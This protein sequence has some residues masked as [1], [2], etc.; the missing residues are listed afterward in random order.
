MSDNFEKFVR[1]NRRDFDSETPAA[2]VWEKIETSLPK[3]QVRRFTIRDIYKWSAAAAIVVVVLTSAYF[4]IFQRNSHEPKTNK[5]VVTVTPNEADRIV[6]EYADEFNAVYRAIGERSLELKTNTAAYP[7]LYRQFQED[8]ASLD[9][10]Y[11][12]LMK[13]ADHSPNQDLLYQAIIQNLR[14]RADLLSRQL[15]ITHELKNKTKKSNS[16]EKEI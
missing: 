7:E 11:Q 4:L 5:P 15:M 1:N 3:Q 9:S 12:A 14:L 8:M 13:Q 2:S 6:P 10:A 16:H